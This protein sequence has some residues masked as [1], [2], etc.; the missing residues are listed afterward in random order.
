M[1]IT[2]SAISALAQRFTSKLVHAGQKLDAPFIGQGHIKKLKKPQAAGVVNVKGNISTYVVNDGGTMPTGTTVDLGQLTYVGKALVTRLA[3]PRIAAAMA[4]GGDDGI[5]LV[6]EELGACAESLN[7]RL[8]H[9]TL[10][11]QRKGLVTTTLLGSTTTV[12]ASATS[13][14]VTDPT[15]YIVG[16]KYTVL[17]T[18]AS[19]AVI[20]SFQV[21]AVFHNG[22]NWTVSLVDAVTTGWVGVDGTADKIVY[23]EQNAAAINTTDG[24]KS[25]YDV[26]NGTTAIHG[27][28]F[29]SPADW[30]G[31]LDTTTTAAITASTLMTAMTKILRRRNKK[32]T[33]VVLNSSE[34]QTLFEAQD[35]RL[36]FYAND[37]LD[38]YGNTQRVNGVPVVEDNNMPNSYCLLFQKD[39]VK[40]HEFQDFAPVVDGGS[41]GSMGRSSLFVNPSSLAWDLPIEG[42]YNI[43]PERRNG[44][45]MFTALGTA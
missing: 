38:S 25:C 23:F 17:D 45:Y 4:Q 40:L 13:F 27:E 31:M 29:T 15:D 37:T 36:T 30:A 19:N 41:T 8:D 2:A 3:I 20:E 39:D 12:A 44:C 42:Y 10:V 21:K 22:T 5:D 26:C 6:M 7:R 9:E 14:F 35:T 18:S 33:A 16:Q 1:A 34:A 32:P 28:T 43:R 11:G 24:M